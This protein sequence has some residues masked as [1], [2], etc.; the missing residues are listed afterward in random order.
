MRV[1][2]VEQN[3]NYT[4]ENVCIYYIHRYYTIYIYM[5]AYDKHLCYMML[6]KNYFIYYH[7]YYDGKVEIA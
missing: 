5:Y 7:Y 4:H 6:A 1:Y 3:R 2:K